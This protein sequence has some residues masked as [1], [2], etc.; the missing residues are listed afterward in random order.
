MTEIIVIIALTAA[1]ASI[2]AGIYSRIKTRRILKSINSML[3]SAIDGSFSEQRFDE[4]E[5]SALEN[6][7]WQYLSSSEISARKTAEEKDKIKTLIA[8]ISHQTKT[9]VSNIRLYS[10]LLTE[11]VL[12]D[13]L[14]E[15]AERINNQSEKLSFLITSLVKLSRLETGIIALNAEKTEIAPMLKEIEAQA[16]PKAESKELSISIECGAEKAV[17]DRKWTSEA[18]WNIVDNAIKYTEKGG[19]KITV[20]DYEMFACIKISDTGRGIPE[21]E[22][23]KIFSRFYRSENVSK[24]E[25]LGIGLYLSRQIITSENGY[26]KVISEKGK[27]S[28]FSVFL[29][30]L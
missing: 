19:I 24:E 10:E 4:T 22:Q 14:K 27:G 2:S 13:E 28:E 26:I 8:D 12:S 21:E 1:V 23:A 6:K 3:D 11:N 9:P 29:S 20:K 17:F 18:V 25:G 7:L 30:K 5:L 16:K 15:Y